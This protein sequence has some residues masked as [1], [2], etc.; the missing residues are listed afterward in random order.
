MASRLKGRSAVITGAAGGIGLATARALA[1]EGARVAISDVRADTIDAAA[2]A[3]RSEGFDVRAERL[4]VRDRGAVQDYAARLAAESFTTDILVNNAGLTVYGSFEEHSLEQ[5]ERVLDVNLRGV[6]YGCHAFLPQLKRSKKAHIVNISSMFGL[7]GVPNQTA[8][9]ASKWAVRGF[10]DSLRAELAGTPVRVACVH[11]GGIA[12][13][14]IDNADLGSGAKRDARPSIAEF[15]R[16]NAAPPEAVADR[17]VRA[18][19]HD[20]ARVLVTPETWATEVATRLL[21]G[22]VITRV[23]R[24]AGRRVAGA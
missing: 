21:P 14:I 11:P 19:H 22:G 18:I 16:R 10:S 12:T 4:D 2:Q 24:L 9:C 20:R 3:L 5:F 1:R 6:V 15:F 13:G 17:I 23:V 7:V 8:Y